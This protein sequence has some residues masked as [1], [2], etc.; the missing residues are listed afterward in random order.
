[1]KM[2]GSSPAMM[3]VGQALPLLEIPGSSP[4]MTRLKARHF[5]VGITKS[6]PARMPVGQREVTVFRR[7]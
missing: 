4:G 2:A 1:M 7:V 6:A 5:I 3:K